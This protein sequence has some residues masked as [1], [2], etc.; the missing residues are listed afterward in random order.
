MAGPG[1]ARYADRMLTSTPSAAVPRTPQI[2]R[3]QHWLAQHRG[4]HFD[5]YDALW[6]W[7]VTDLDAFWQSVWAGAVFCAVWAALVALVRA[8]CCSFVAALTADS[9]TVQSGV[10]VPVL[11]R[12][13]RRAVTGVQLLRTPLLWA[14][15]CTVLLVR[16]PGLQLVLPGIPAAQATALAA[17]LM[18]GNV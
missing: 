18:E 2:R 5:R 6:R 15:G 11:H 8:R 7:S 4:L 12:I 9:V 17:V 10:A 13:P 3:Y 1:G 16:S 14:A